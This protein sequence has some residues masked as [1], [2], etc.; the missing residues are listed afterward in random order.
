MCHLGFRS[1]RFQAQLQRLLVV[2]NSSLITILTN[3]KRPTPSTA[4]NNCTGTDLEHGHVSQGAEHVDE[5]DGV[6]A[7]FR[8]DEAGGVET[9]N[10]ME[11]GRVEGG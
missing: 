4:H 5:H 7:G 6:A 11:R 8:E 9:W 3:V 2:F 10:G 1:A